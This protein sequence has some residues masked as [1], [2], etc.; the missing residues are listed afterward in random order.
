MPADGGFD[1]IKAVSSVSKTEG[2]HR[3]RPSKKG[4]GGLRRVDLAAYDRLYPNSNSGL[5]R[6]RPTRA[7][8]TKALAA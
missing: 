5:E 7:Q 8:S 2:R 1:R 3:C 6:N 4:M